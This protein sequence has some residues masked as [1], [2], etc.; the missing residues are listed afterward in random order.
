MLARV[1]H[2]GH[3][4]KEIGKGALIVVVALAIVA[5]VNRTEIGRKALGS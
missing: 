2:A 1:A 5:A 4:L 3:M